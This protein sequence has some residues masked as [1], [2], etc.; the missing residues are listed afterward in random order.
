MVCS[1][2][3]A[4]AVVDDLEFDLVRGHSEGNSARCGVRV[5]HDVGERFQRTSHSRTPARGSMHTPAT[6]AVI[7]A[8]QGS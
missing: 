8:P 1:L 3:H 7:C 4:L 5:M 6:T 2:P